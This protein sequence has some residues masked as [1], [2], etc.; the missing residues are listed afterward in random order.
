MRRVSAA[1][2]NPGRPIARNTVCQGRVMPM[3][4]RSIG[5]IAVIALITCPPITSASPEPIGMPR[6]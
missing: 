1:R 2:I 5:P 4:G 3:T 6:P